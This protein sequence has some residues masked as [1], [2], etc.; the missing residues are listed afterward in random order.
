MA[1]KPMNGW[2]TPGPQ[3]IPVDDIMSHLYFLT[4]KKWNSVRCGGDFD[5]VVIGSSF[6]AL[7][8]THQAIKNNPDAK[9]LIID[10]GTYFHPEHFQ[11]LP[12]AYSKTVGG[13]SET[14][15]WK[16][17]DDTHNGKYIHYLHG[18]N[19]FFGGRSSFWSA[20]CPEP[21]NE[22]MADWPPAVMKKIKKY[23]P[24]AKKL[25][26]VVPANEISSHE[27]GDKIFGKLQD[28]VHDALT[29]APSDIEAITRV[30]HAPLAVKAD[31]YRSEI[32]T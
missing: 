30:I 9:I 12:P 6:C 29:P 31:Q 25:L 7:G 3:E 11:N 20:W 23:F 15:H 4:D 10:R 26:N 1:N 18:M 28:A 16:I 32:I 22:E 14:F 17:T 5:Y 19:N 27:P 24:D 21:T 8:F 2:P 13:K